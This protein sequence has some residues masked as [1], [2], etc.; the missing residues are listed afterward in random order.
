MPN[1]KLI[2]TNPE[3]LQEMITNALA[4]VQPQQ[5]LQNP[6]SQPKEEFISREELAKRLGVS[7]VSLWKWRKSGKFSFIK[8]GRRVLF[9]WQQVLVD[10]KRFTVN[11]KVARRE[12]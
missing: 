12:K 2:H 1:Q 7:P 9:D 11:T 8:L 4:K 5:E 6:A 3:E 10:L